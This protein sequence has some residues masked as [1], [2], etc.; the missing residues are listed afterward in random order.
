MEIFTITLLVIYI[1]N[2]SMTL[3]HLGGSYPR[4]REVKKGDDFITLILIILFAIWAGY[5]IF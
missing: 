2:I 4:V 1:L 3:V 5:L